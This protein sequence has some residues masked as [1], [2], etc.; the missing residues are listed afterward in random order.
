MDATLIEAARTLPTAN[1][2]DCMSRILAGGTS[3]RPYYTGGQM[4]GPAYTVR[5]RPGDNLMVHCALDRAEPGDVLVVDAGGDLTNA[6][7]G[8]IMIAYAASR[9]LAGIIINGAVRDSDALLKGDFPVFAAG[10]THR[11][12]YRDGPGEIGGTVSL[13]GMIVS[14]GDLVVGDGDGVISV[15]AD[16]SGDILA[17]ARKKHDAEEKSL[18]RI[19][20]GEGLDRAWVAKALADAGV[21]DDG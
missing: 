18:S 4:V 8:E 20:A 9:G 14:P 5:T 2:S 1:I 13:N 12:P 7:V 11:G 19:K 3:L 10:V 21:R 16:A 15:P 17:A 6:I